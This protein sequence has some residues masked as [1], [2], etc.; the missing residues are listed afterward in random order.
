M[1]E[2][3]QASHWHGKRFT[4][5]HASWRA[6][7]GRTRESLRGDAWGCVGMRGDAG[8]VK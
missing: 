6:N 2:V 7:E 4:P 8:Q 5:W 3:K 1:T